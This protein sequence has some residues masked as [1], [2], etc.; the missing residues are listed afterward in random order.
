MWM[1]MRCI[2]YCYV[3]DKSG[4]CAYVKKVGVY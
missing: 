3:V 4:M 2:G 1:V